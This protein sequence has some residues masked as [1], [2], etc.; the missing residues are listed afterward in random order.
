LVGVEVL[1]K[2]GVADGVPAAGVGVAVAEVVDSDTVLRMVTELPAAR[3]PR[4]HCIA[5]PTSTVLADTE[6]VRASALPLFLTWV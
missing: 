5:M 2:V 1:V 3:E 6:L 4:F